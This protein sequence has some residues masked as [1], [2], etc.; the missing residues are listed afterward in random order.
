MVPNAQGVLDIA[1][2]ENALQAVLT[3]EPRLFGLADID[4]EYIVNIDSSDMKPSIWDRLAQAIHSVY[5]QYDGFVV[6]HGTD[7]MA[8]TASAI[9]FALRQLGKPVI[10]TGAQ[11]SGHRIESDARRNLVNAVMVACKNIAGV[12]LL[13][14]ERILL[15]VRSTKISHSKLNAFA[16]FNWPRLGEVGRM[17]Q[18]IPNVPPRSEQ[19]LLLE[20]GFAADIAVLS[21][22]PGMPASILDHLLDHGIKGIV[23]NA[24]GTGNIPQVYLP[25]LE[26]AHQ[27]NIPVVIRTQCLE[28]STQMSVYA[29]GEKA[30]SCGVI[31][32]FDMSLEATITKLMWALKRGTTIDAIKTIIHTNY[33]GEINCNGHLTTG[34]H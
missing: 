9:T 18:L 15:G 17:I 21:L 3:M 10:F 33:A 23:L 27:K 14:G 7:T 8:Y 2:K 11:I 5:S 24:Y 19:E 34:N 22:A 16:S 29:T 12:F 4:L 26:R 30:L 25:S 1:S 20:C 28:G 32:G 31:E 13:V 6:L